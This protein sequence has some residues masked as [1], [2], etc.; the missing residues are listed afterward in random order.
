[1]RLQR[2][3]RALQ[4]L[5]RQVRLLRIY[6]RWGELVF[7]R[8]NFPAN[9]SNLGWDGRFRGKDFPTDVLVFYAEIEMPDGRLLV[10]SGDVTL[11]R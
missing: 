6:S 2:G 7:E 5:H 4:E 8:A 1:M 3:L 9:Q 10:R 11:I